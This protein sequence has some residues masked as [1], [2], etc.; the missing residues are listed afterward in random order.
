MLTAT[1]KYV[2]SSNLGADFTPTLGK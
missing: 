1:A 2:C